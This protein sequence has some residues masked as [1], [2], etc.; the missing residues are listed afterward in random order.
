MA[1]IMITDNV[2]LSIFT[3]IMLFF[4][5]ALTEIGGGYLVWKWIRERKGVVFGIV[6]GIVL[7]IYGIIPTLQPSNFGR[8]YAAY[9]GIFIIS[10]IIWGILVDKKKPDRYEVI[11]SLTAILGAIIIFYAPR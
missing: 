1:E 7:F 11:G 5:A 4:I 10:A 3:S 9:G 6:G 8:V 2:A